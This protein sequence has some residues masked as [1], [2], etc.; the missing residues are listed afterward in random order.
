MEEIAL[1]L[2]CESNSTGDSEDI[3]AMRTRINLSYDEERLQLRQRMHQLAQDPR[4]QEA[5][6][7]SSPDMFENVWTRYL[8]S[9][10]RP[11]TSDTRRIERRV[12]GYL[13]RLCA[14]NETT[15]FFGPMGYGEVSGD[16]DKIEFLDA[17]KQTRKTF[18]AYWA[19]EALART[20]ATEPEIWKALPIRRNPLFGIDEA[21]AEAR[22][23]SLDLAH[24]LSTDQMNLLKAIANTGRA[25]SIAALLG[26][27]LS[28][29]EATAMSLFRLGILVR[30]IWFRSDESDT[31]GNLREAIEKLPVTS[32]RE[33]WLANLSEVD[34]LRGQFENAELAERRIL[35]KALE[36]RFN[37]L[38][39]VPARRAGGRLYTDR[40]IINEEASSPF[41]LRV[42]RKAAEKLAAALSPLLEI[43][44]AYG[45]KIQTNCAQAVSDHLVATDTA[46]SFTKFAT[47]LRELQVDHPA[48]PLVVAQGAEPMQL[49]VDACGTSSD[50]SRFALPDLCLGR[51]VDGTLHV[52]VARIHHHLLTRGWLFTFH[53]DL[54]RVDQ[55]AKGWLDREGLSDP[56]IALASGR[57]NK[58]FYTFPGPRIAHVSAETAGHSDA[59]FAAAD[60]TVRMEAGC[61]VLR[62][63]APEQKRLL[64]YLPLADLTQHPPFA[65]LAHPLVVQAPIAAEAPH[66]PRFN[67]DQ[68]TY[69]RERWK[70]SLEGWTRLSGFALFLEM[71]R[72]K[73]RLGLPRFVFAR[74]PAERKPFLV[75][76]DSPLSIDLLRHYVREA[77]TATFEEMLPSPE[78]LWLRDKNGRYTFEI[79]MQVERRAKSA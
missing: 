33:R 37:T 22:C 75:D 36:A 26:V 51:R 25:E 30:R 74:V 46:I 65:A 56:L 60:L 55:V 45:E 48:S 20:A 52:T 24:P 50:G 53:P 73:I 14:K 77:G 29:V 19:V 6:F 35:L 70:A 59:V 41:R 17:P 23:D 69:Q 5:V 43:S 49:P 78:D 42:G 39:R 16:D 21:R 3:R 11:D 4:V 13:Q 61:P 2:K 28:V 57:H 7:L 32:A 47:L 12:Y 71:Q 76:T 64:L 79:R 68:A 63:P 1:L 58:G 38:T 54:D 72:E 8:E 27:K 40:L 44:A 66:A 18:I 34:V 67:V 10:L 62:S 31:L 9:P 15:S